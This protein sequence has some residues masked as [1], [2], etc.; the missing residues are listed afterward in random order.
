MM[1]IFLQDIYFQFYLFFLI[2][3]NIHDFNCGQLTCLCMSPFV[4]LTICAISNHFNQFK[5][6]CRVLWEIKVQVFLEQDEMSKLISSL[7][8]RPLGQC[9]PRN[10]WCSQPLSLNA[11]PSLLSFQLNSR[12]E[13]V[14]NHDVSCK[15]LQTLASAHFEVRKFCKLSCTD[16]INYKFHHKSWTWYKV[17]AYLCYIP[18]GGG[19]LISTSSLT[20]P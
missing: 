3:C 19:W 10:N 4:Y 1:W 16:G 2:L 7:L 5:D 14:A 12:E 15:C 9:R 18:R 8:L 20:T 11:V 6:P 13:G 17:T